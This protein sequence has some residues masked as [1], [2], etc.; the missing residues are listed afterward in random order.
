VKTKKK[1]IDPD[2]RRKYFSDEKEFRSRLASYQDSLNLY[3][4]WKLSPEKE[5]RIREEGT[6]YPK[7]EGTVRYY[8]NWEDTP[9]DI[10]DRYSADKINPIGVYHKK[11]I[12]PSLSI[13]SGGYEYQGVHWPKY[14]KPKVEPILNTKTEVKPKGIDLK[15]SPSKVGVKKSLPK[16]IDKIAMDA[17]GTTVYVTVNGKTTS[18]PKKDYANWRIANKDLYDKYIESR[19]R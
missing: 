19:R 18:M 17:S 1:P 10:K 8:T 6:P 11:V 15:M 4:R 13:I 3:D 14:I 5:K 9:N 12:D 2:P 7:H 16:S